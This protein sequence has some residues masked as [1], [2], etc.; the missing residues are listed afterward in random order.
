MLD[1][2]NYTK[3]EDGSFTKTVSNTSIVTD[4]ALELDALKA[5]VTN[6]QIGQAKTLLMK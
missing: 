3:N 5:T 1:T 4:A 6:L 2:I